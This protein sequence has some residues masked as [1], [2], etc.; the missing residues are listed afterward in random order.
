MK[1][2]IFCSGHMYSRDESG[3]VLSTKTTSKV[4]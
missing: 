1:S 4:G 2:S 3:E